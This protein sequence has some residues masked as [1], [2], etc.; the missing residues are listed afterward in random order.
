MYAHSGSKLYRLNAATL[1]AEPIGTM[2]GLGTQSLTDLAIDK[3]DKMVGITLD[4]LFSID[5]TTGA[6]T[7]IRD[8]SQ[9]GQNLTSLS[10]VPSDLN[11]PNSPDI[12]VAANS[13]GEVFQI[14]PATGS[15]TKIGDYGTAAL[16]KIRS[17]GDLFGV[18]GVGIFATV[19]VGE[20]TPGTPD[21]LAELDPA[22]NWKA[23]LRP[24]DTGFD[25]IFGV[26]FW[27]GIIYGFV[28]AGDPA[29]GK[30]IQI[31]PQTGAGTLLSSSDIRWF[32]AGVATD[33]PIFE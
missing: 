1:A 20:G 11:D 7:L 13:F 21:F 28:D 27:G 22:N 15:A 8:L 25:K 31:D 6:A 9:D 24:N 16:G 5:A 3:D 32:G 12:L 19:D 10:F 33:A 4:K 14:D 30:M 17:S 26:G 29:G 2:S 23:T 18:R